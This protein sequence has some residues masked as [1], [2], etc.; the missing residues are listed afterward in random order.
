MYNYIIY[1]S[2]NIID[3]IVCLIHEHKQIFVDNLNIAGENY[4]NKHRP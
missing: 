1:S 4:E 2:S 3:I